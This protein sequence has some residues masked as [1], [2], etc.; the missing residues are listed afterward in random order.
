[1]YNRIKYILKKSFQNGKKFNYKRRR[2]STFPE[3]QNPNSN[4]F[5]YISVALVCG[6]YYKIREEGD[7]PSRI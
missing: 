3:N 1:M 4:P 7:P 2:F 6:I 5:T